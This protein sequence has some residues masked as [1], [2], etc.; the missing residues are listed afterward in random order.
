MSTRGL[1]S[2]FT[3]LVLLNF[4]STRH[5]CAQQKDP[6]PAIG[7][8]QGTL[9]AGQSKLRLVIKITASEDGTL[10]GSLDSPDQGASDIPASGVQISGDSVVVMMNSIHGAY[11]GVLGSGKDSLHG[12]WK[13]GGMSFPLSLARSGSVPEIRRPQIPAKP[14][15]YGEEEV[16]YENKA[17]GVRLTGTLTLPRETGP[18]G[19]KGPFPAVILITGS[20]PQDRDESLFGHKPFLVLADFLTRRGIAVLR[21]DD[22]GIGGSTGSVMQSTT[23]DFAGDVQAGIRF[24]KQRADIDKKRIGLIGHS[25]GGIVAPLVAAESPDV[26]FIVLM[27]GTGLTGEEILVLQT[28]LIARAAGTTEEEI[29]K[30]LARNQQ[31]YSILKSESDS[32]KLAEKLT[33][34]LQSTWDE[35]GKGYQKQGLEMEKA[36]TPQVRQMTSLWFR[37]FLTFDPRATLMKVRCPVLAINGEKDLQVPPVEN[38]REIGKAL[39]DGGNTRV[40][41]KELPGLNH[42]FQTSKTGSPTEYG[43]IEE[44]MSPSALGV[45]GEWIG[46]Q[47]KR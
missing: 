14:Y 17:A 35:W 40:T 36:I 43:S 46:Q 19:L 1:N 32:I 18:E 26:A 3:I 11:E 33:T 37:F 28:D 13:Q 25:E 45:I 8:W 20:G 6:S 10:K 27:A 2:A 9:A 22:R 16:S 47:V 30:T 44:T 15:P 29:R 42:L 23:A 12:T 7:V 24:L 4:L 34:H 31:L 21:V 39:R 41:I 5:A 38:L